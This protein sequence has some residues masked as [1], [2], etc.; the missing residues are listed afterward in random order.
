M[1]LIAYTG[2][3]IHTEMG[4]IRAGDEGTVE[5]QDGGWYGVEFTAIGAY[6]TVRVTDT[7][8]I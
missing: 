2:D 7:E 8:E 3:D 1:T 5:H 4:T 6:V